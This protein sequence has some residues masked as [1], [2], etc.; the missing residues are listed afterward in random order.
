MDETN[1]DFKHQLCGQNQ[2]EDVRQ[3]QTLMSQTR[4][5]SCDASS[6]T[7]LLHI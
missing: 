7:M 1:V 4:L 6:K 5:L 2:M 3:W